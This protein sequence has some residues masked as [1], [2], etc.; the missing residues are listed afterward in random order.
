M[1]SDR[2]PSSFSFKWDTVLSIGH[3]KALLLLRTKWVKQ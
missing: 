1:F 2:S 3:L